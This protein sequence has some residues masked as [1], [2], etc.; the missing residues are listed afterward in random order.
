LTGS[1]SS[2]LHRYAQEAL[3]YRREATSARDFWRVMRVRLSQSKI[4]R[5]VCPRPI[6]ID[7]SLRSLGRGVRLRSHTTDISVLGEIVVS[8]SYEVAASA[9]PEAR[10]IVDLGANIGLASRW[11]LQR[12]PQAR[13]VSVEP[14]RENVAVLRHNLAPFAERASVID[15][16]V[17]ARARR[18]SLIRTSGREDGHSMRDVAH[19]ADTDVVTMP[20]VLSVLGSD[21]VDLLKCDIEGAESELF[22]SS[23]AW[24][25]GVG[26]LAVECHGDF[27][28]QRLLEALS[29]NGVGAR[30]IMLERTPQF[31]CEQIVLALTGHE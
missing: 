31:G 22:E 28:A 13:I 14:E 12:F 11:L 26:V 17:G 6:V 3:T 23:A 18:V 24:I 5:L 27:T 7:V 9:A 16:C 19:G 10:T 29:S 30:T 4:G 1:I 15:A 20:D 25:S 8:R 2:R 21:R